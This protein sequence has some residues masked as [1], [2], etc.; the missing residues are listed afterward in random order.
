VRRYY[1]SIQDYIVLFSIFYLIQGPSTILQVHF[2]HFSLYLLQPRDILIAYRYAI[3][4]HP[5]M[6]AASVSW[7]LF[8]L[9]LF[10]VPVLFCILEATFLP[11][12]LWKGWADCCSAV[13]ETILLSLAYTPFPGSDG[14]A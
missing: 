12:C 7:R 13:Q 1:W 10:T 11:A 5:H 9:P 14:P 8:C 6:E 2:L 3:A 4:W